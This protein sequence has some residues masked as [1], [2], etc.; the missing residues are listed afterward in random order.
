MTMFECCHNPGLEELV[1]ML[2]GE[3]HL[4]PTCSLAHVKLRIGKWRERDYET[5]G[6]LAELWR[7]RDLT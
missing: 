2:T 3:I 4:M 6:Q 7:P 5:R 1:E